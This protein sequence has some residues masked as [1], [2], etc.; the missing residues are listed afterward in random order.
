MTDYTYYTASTLDGFLAD[1]DDSLD[2]LLSQP[3]DE[4]GPFSIA[5]LMAATGVIV[6]GATTYEWVLE[7]TPDEPWPYPDQQTFVFSHRE[8]PLVHPTVR[9]I[10]GSPA[11]HRELLETA[12]GELGVWVVGGGGLA[13]AFAADGMLDEMVVCYAPVALGA[14]RPLFTRPFD[15]EL[16]ETARNKAFVIA[17][18]RVVGARGPSQ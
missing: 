9:V 13:A 10:S 3:I 1:P 17:R 4:D 8:L 2:W 7:H 18:Y 15:F 6:M 16:L 12:A 11:E 14:G 5:D